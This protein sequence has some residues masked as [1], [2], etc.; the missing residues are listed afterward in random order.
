MSQN[1]EVQ[2]PRAPA[3][4]VITCVNCH[5]VMPSE[6]RFC[7]NCGFRLGEG[8]A[9][10]TPTVRFEGTTVPAMTA[11]GVPAPIK[12]K[13]RLSGMAW[14]FMALL[15]FF[16]VAAGLT[17]L[18]SPNRT[19]RGIAGVS[20]PAKPKSYLGVVDDFETIDDGNGVTF[21]AV[22]APDT[23]ADKAGLVGGDII[24]SFDGQA[25][26]DD[27]QMRDLMTE[28][29]IGKTV[30]IEY[31]R[32]GEK[33]TTKLTTVSAEENRR[34]TMLFDRR[35]EGRGSFGYEPGDAE[36]VEI[37]GTK[38]SGVKLN[39]ISTSRPADLAGV[40]NGDIVIEFDKVP[41]RTREEFRMRV[42]RAMPYSTVDVVVMRGND[43]N[44]ERLV[45]P[46]KMGKQ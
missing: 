3:P 43:E 40:K 7:R 27:D 6:L 18:I 4:S 10:Y 14:I 29:T 25:V 19:A 15:F 5:S 11:S 17:A 37:P 28:T 20:A 8:V 22:S 12:K 39:T 35:P 21:A 13:K 46:V 45:I 42:R 32:D 26:H 30:D 24:I 16:V 34:L 38:I 23:P 44:L 41:I 1:P 9:E 36:Q 33:K 2:T 31:L